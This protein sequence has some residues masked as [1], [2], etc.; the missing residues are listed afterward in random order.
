LFNKQVFRELK[1]EHNLSKK[2]LKQYLLDVAPSV[3]E[4]QPREVNIVVDATHFGKR[5]EESEWCVIVFRDPVKKENLWWKFC[6][7]ERDIYY[8]EGKEYLENLG[9]VIKSVTGDGNLSYEGF[10]LMNM[11]FKC[12]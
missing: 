10:F 6:N 1:E 5:K 7:L 8:Q 2:I 11:Y 3:K 4:H 12:V 9:Y